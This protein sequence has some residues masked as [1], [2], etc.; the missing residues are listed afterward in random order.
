MGNLI[1][2]FEQRFTESRTCQGCGVSRRPA[3]RYLR[4]WTA[5]EHCTADYCYPCRGDL[6]VSDN[7]ADFWNAKETLIRYR[8]CLS[9][10]SVMEET[11]LP[12]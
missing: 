2:S 7:G 9:C 6:E 12:H 4:G 3:V 8:T 10:Q 1:Q 5:C 11:V